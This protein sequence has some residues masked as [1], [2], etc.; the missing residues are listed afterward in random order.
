MYE[1]IF[2]GLQ[3]GSLDYCEEYTMCKQ[4]GAGGEVCCKVYCE[5]S[6]PGLR[7]P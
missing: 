7:C 3:I 1:R 5:V 6:C 2:C 4:L